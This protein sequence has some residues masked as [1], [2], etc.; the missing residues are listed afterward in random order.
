MVT[1]SISGTCHHEKTSLAGVNSFNHLCFKNKFDKSSRHDSLAVKT[2]IEN[3]IFCGS[4][5]ILSFF[6]KYVRWL[7]VPS[8]GHITTHRYLFAQER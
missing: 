3:T 5:L 4:L 8:E 7:Y 6:L 2:P 1:C